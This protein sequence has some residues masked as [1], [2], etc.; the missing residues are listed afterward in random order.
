MPIQLVSGGL[1]YVFVCSKSVFG[2]NNF[3]AGRISFIMY[4]QL[5]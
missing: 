2:I 4:I 5:Y 3:V 1:A